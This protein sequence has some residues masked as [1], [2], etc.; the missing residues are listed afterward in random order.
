MHDFGVK[1]EVNAPATGDTWTAS[2]IGKLKLPDSFPV[3]L[4]ILAC[5]LVLFVWGIALPK[6]A[7][8]EI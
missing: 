7:V 4:L 8:H 1:M 6:N 5:F 3:V 2:C